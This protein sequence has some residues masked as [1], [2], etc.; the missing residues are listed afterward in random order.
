M[1]PNQNLESSPRANQSTW[2]LRV[3]LGEPGFHLFLPSYLSFECVITKISESSL[4]A[5]LSTW[6]L[7]VSLGEPG[8]HLFL[9]SYLSFEC[10][11]TKISERDFKGQSWRARI[12][13]LPTFLPWFWTCPNQNFGE[14]SA[15]NPIYLDFKGE[16]W[17]ARIPPLPT[18]LPWFWMC[19]NQNFG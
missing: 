4:R 2:I 11:L 17:R 8:F 16:S 10:V 15:S 18:F 9:P 12:P 1:C 19:P 14:L 3:S 7:R 13:P 6:I 5:T